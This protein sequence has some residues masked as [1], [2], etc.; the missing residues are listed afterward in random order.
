VARSLTVLLFAGA[1]E[2]VGT[3]E[4][5]LELAHDRTPVAEVLRTL[6]REYPRL[7]PILAVSRLVR[8]GEY[9]RGTA[10][11]VGPGDELAIHPPY[12]GG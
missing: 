9:L 11:A 3:S 5:R 10:G 8:N 2:A 4:L 12:S 6:R 1:R 7:I